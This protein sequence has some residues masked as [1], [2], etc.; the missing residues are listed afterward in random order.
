MKERIDQKAGGEDVDQILGSAELES[1][2]GM[3]AREV[4]FPQFGTA[5]QAGDEYEVMNNFPEQGDLMQSLEQSQQL[6][7]ALSPEAIE[8]VIADSPFTGEDFLALPEE[9]RSAALDLAEDT[10]VA[11]ALSQEVPTARV[12]A[13][14]SE[15]SLGGE[16][17]LAA[18][19]MQ[20]GRA[21]G[22]ALVVG[23]GAMLVPGTAGAHDNDKNVFRAFGDNVAHGVRRDVREA[24]RDSGAVLGGVARI[25]I[26]R[27]INQVAVRILQG[28]GVPVEQAPEEVVVVPRSVPGA[29]IGVYDGGMPPPNIN[30]GLGYDNHGYGGRQMESGERVRI[31]EEIGR[32]MS[33]ERALSIQ[34]G[35]GRRT[36]MNTYAELSR[37]RND[38]SLRARY[39][40]ERSN[41]EYTVGMVRTVRGQIQDLGA[42]LS[43]TP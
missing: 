8:K 39:D 42:K 10:A 25:I 18:K 32:L 17:S 28:A 40:A 1:T 21:L 27:S 14:S 19:S 16:Q 33:Q 36:V 20:W 23:L 13:V 35:N 29:D 41:Y 22:A 31:R 43:Y 37:S 7:D 5:G 34:A 26:D 4:E 30:T 38:L 15:F 2:I 12:A 11:V 9:D 6:W 3:D 24:G